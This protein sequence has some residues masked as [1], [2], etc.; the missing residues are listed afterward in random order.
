MLRASYFSGTTQQSSL[1]ELFNKIFSLIINTTLRSDIRRKFLLRFWQ[2]LDA[3]FSLMI[4]FSSRV[5]F[6][7]NFDFYWINNHFWRWQITFGPLSLN[8]SVVSNYS[9]SFTSD[10]SQNWIAVP[11]DKQFFLV[12]HQIFPKIFS[13]SFDHY[14][15]FNLIGDISFARAISTKGFFLWTT[16]KR[17]K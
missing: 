6:W 7:I 2:T 1:H 12:F 5:V 9:I 17:Q 3:L 4:F 8:Y 13:V 10:H 15:E 11:L 14:A 16:E